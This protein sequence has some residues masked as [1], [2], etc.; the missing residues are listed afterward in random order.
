MKA[1]QL[2]GIRPFDLIRSDIFRLTG[3]EGVEIIEA[4]GKLHRKGSL[5][6]KMQGDVVEFDLKAKK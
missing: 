3:L 4:L 2:A 1:L 5:H 6:F